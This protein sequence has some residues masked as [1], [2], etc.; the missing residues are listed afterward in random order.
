MPK[1][2]RDGK[3]NL[4]FPL[5]DTNDPIAINPSELEDEL[6]DLI[7]TSGAWEEC[8]SSGEEPDENDPKLLAELH[9]FLSGS[10]SVT[11]LPL[12]DEPIINKRTQ[13]PHPGVSRDK[14]SIERPVEVDPKLLAELQEFISADEPVTKLTV[15]E[16]STQSANSGVSLDEV[17]TRITGY[18]AT[19][20][21]LQSTQPVDGAKIRR[22]ERILKQLESIATRISN[23]HLVNADELPAPAPPLAPLPSAYQPSATPAS[24][25]AAVENQNKQSSNQ[26]AEPL[27]APTSSAV[28]LQA[29][30]HRCQEYKVAAIRARDAG[31][32]P[33]AKK[34]LGAVKF[35]ESMVPKIE[36][37][38]EQFDPDSDMPPTPEEFLSMPD[39]ESDDTT[40]SSAPHAPNTQQPQLPRAVLSSTV[41]SENLQMRL[42]YFKNQL[43]ES[44]SNPSDTS[45]TRRFMRIITQYEQALRAFDHGLANYAYSDLPPPPNCPVLSNPASLQRTLGDG[46]NPKSHLGQR[47]ADMSKNERIVALL[48]K[49]QVELK[50][51][52]LKAK[53]AGNIELA[54]THLRAACR[55]DPM[56]S[57]AEA[58][59]PFD[60][61]SLPPPPKPL[62]VAPRTQATMFSGPILSGITC[63]PPDVFRLELKALHSQ[64]ERNTCV[65]QLLE[66]QAKEASERALQ[67]EQ[68]GLHEIA[69]KMSEL[70]RIGEISVRSFRSRMLSGSSPSYVFEKANIPQL[71]MNQ[72][73]GDDVLEVTV[74]RGFTYPL[75]SDIS[76]VDKLDTQVE[77]QLPAPSVDTP[78]KHLTSWHKHTADP[79]YDSVARFQVD[80]KSRSFN[81][82]L[83]R[84]LKATIYYS[85]GLLRSARVLGTAQF[86]LDELAT[87][88]TVTQTVS[89]MDGRKA[90]GGG[91]ELRLRQRSCGAGPRITSMEKPW[92]VLQFTSTS[93]PPPPAAH[94]RVS[95]TTVGR[96]SP[97]QHNP[98]SP[99]E[100]HPM[101]KSFD[102]SR[103]P[104]RGGVGL[105]NVDG[106]ERSKTPVSIEVLKRDQKY[107]AERLH[108]PDGMRNKS[109]L[110]SVTRK[111][112]EL[113]HRFS[114]ADAA[115][116]KKIYVEQL[117]DLYDL[118]H[119]KLTDAVRRGDEVEILKYSERLKLVKQEIYGFRSS[120]G[121]Q[122][123]KSCHP[124]YRTNAATVHEVS[125]N[126]S[127]S[128]RDPQLASGRKN[129]NNIPAIPSPHYPNTSRR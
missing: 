28:P 128:W 81:L 66:K 102:S 112:E 17:A 38:E 125:Q 60:I 27:A 4:V 88:A 62:T 16:E 72:D 2:S 33:E 89:L 83:K 42:N 106:R 96:E 10:E 124:V 21:Q 54:K 91:L 44:K 61:S 117:K 7:G 97:S 104:T 127:A 70:F 64:E 39:D 25:V 103:Q 107:F 126:Q 65:L 26:H 101:N 100:C 3:M 93:R 129:R 92:L 58:G 82:L 18:R 34:L 115:Y 80:T 67:F 120:T 23:G 55:I 46:S 53:E 71:N 119:A 5:L 87:S 36:S 35:I 114:G 73:L 15:T 109:K 24:M 14:V 110:E 37:G 40:P 69:A 48:K 85:R 105:R 77:L 9:E 57:S 68:A 31:R 56:I 47:S 30:K 98:S 113:E 59:I 123:E 99:Q 74:V 122:P 78:Q 108:G 52:A 75:P 51:A 22:Y 79:I 95:P 6:R 1:K 111:L 29:L 76:S 84:K 19:I 121:Q 49:R 20:Q 32:I 12:P 50:S 13:S 11:K 45:R 63:E 43:E 86:P 8:E 116:Q 90:V 94:T 118:I 41:T